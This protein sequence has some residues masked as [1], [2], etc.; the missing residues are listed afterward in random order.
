MGVTVAEARRAGAVRG[1][2]VGVGVAVG[3]G[4]VRSTVGV[5]VAG[6]SVGM[7]ACVGVETKVPGGR[8]IKVGSACVGVGTRVGR[9]MSVGVAPRDRSEG[10]ITRLVRPA[11]YMVAAPI[12]RMMIQ[13]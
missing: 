5:M 13:P 10:R 2:P 7:G 4:F 11:Q 1:V 12:R 9:T 6:G 3:A 8:L